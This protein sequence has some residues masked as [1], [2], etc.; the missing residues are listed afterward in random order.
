MA[1]RIR[2]NYPDGVVF[3]RS[4]NHLVA[5]KQFVIHLWYTKKGANAKN[6]DGR[7]QFAQK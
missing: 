6:P 1:N 3:I 5:K 2:S 4:H 7:R